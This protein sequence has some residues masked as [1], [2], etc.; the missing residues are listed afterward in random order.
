MEILWWVAGALAALAVLFVL[1]ELG[2]RLWLRITARYWIL[3]PGMHMVLQVDRETLPALDPEVHIRVNADGERG[4]ELPEDWSDT[5][6][7]LVVGGSAA[8]CY[9]LDQ[10]NNWPQVVQDTLNDGGGAETLGAQRVHVGN[11]S[12]SLVACESLVRML[13]K[14]LH[15]YERL[16]LVIL[17]V[18][19]SDVVA[20]LEKDTPPT[21]ES[22]DQSASRIFAEHPEGPFG[23]KPRQTAL[24]RVAARLNA[25]FRRP[26]SR[27]YG[28]GK[29]IG[30]NRKMRANAK[31]IL[32]ETPDPTPMVAF[33]ETWLRRLIE[34][35]Q[36]RGARVLVVRQ[37]WFQK[38][39]TPEEQ[40]LLWNFGAGRPY[41]RELDTYYAHSVVFDLMGRIDAAASRVAD[42]L[43]ADQLDL[44]PLLEPSFETFYDILHFTPKGAAEV[45]RHVA[46]AITRSPARSGA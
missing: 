5:Y 25:R 16:D 43:G 22:G 28:A 41:E 42:E 2:T 23:W 32:T 29:T 40:K 9:L 31:T 39:F 44:M 14:T 24:K 33:F 36:A 4:D 37:P 27:K 11:V 15:R 8:E 10:S 3:S 46:D 13:E 1:A 21:I 34:V 35:C 12:R 17:M 19:A 7:A 30:K 38:E 26:I 18:G 20:W 6:R 45:G